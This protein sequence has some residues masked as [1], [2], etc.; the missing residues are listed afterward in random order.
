MKE[1]ERSFK[2][3]NSIYIKGTINL[4]ELNLMVLHSIRI[5]FVLGD[6]NETTINDLDHGFSYK[7]RISLFDGTEWSG[8]SQFSQIINM[9]PGYESI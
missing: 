7:F 8:R 9:T 6:A 2:K 5:H 1:A 4:C 3:L